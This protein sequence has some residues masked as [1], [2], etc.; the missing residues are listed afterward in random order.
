MSRAGTSLAT[1]PSSGLIVSHSAKL[2]A[3][4]PQESNSKR[5]QDCHAL[6]PRRV[7]L[8]FFMIHRAS[9]GVLSRLRAPQ[10]SPVGP[11][12]WPWV[13]S[14]ESSE[15][16]SRYTTSRLCFFFL[17]F[18]EREASGRPQSVGSAAGDRRQAKADIALRRREPNGSESLAQR[19]KSGINNSYCS[20]YS[21]FH[22]SLKA[23]IAKG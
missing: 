10:A 19:D 23:R 22:E 1:Q 8:L 15:T 3:S 18:R 16:F 7:V 13:G 14:A 12:A 17:H 5:H 20:I 21:R 11:A 4:I 9:A 2:V 6:L